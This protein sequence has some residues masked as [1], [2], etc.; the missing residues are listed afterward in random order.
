MNPP[1]LIFV[2]GCNA[3]G[4]SSLIRT[5]FSE[6][7]EYEIIMTDVYKGRSQEVFKGAVKDRKNILLETPFNDEGF[8]NLIDLSKNAGYQSSFVVLFLKSAAQSLERVAARRTF[9]NGLHI[10]EGNVEHNFIEN[11]KNVA[12]YFLYFDESFFLYTGEKGRNQ[13]IMTFQQQKLIEYKANDLTYIQKFAE[14]AH[15]LQRLDKPGFE[16]ITAN[17]D[18]LAET[19]KK[20]KVLPAEK[21][22][23]IHSISPPKKG[24]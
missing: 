15:R 8:K 12:K 17:L 4:K 21:P 3:A 5:H 20:E 11:F 13:L 9:E 22:T 23:K 14:H 1:N 16:T 24:I 19:I 10:S 7:P 2:T 6:F 18:Y